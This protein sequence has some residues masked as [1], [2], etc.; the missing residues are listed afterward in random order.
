VSQDRPD[1]WLTG[2]ISWPH[3]P[4]FRPTVGIFQAQN[5]ILTAPTF[6]EPIE[7]FDGT[8]EWVCAFK[9]R[10]PIQAGEPRKPRLTITCLETGQ[11]LSGQAGFETDFATDGGQQLSIE[12]LL[13]IGRQ[14]RPPWSA[15]GFQS[16]LELSIVDQIQLIYI[17]FLGREPDQS[18]LVYYTRGITSGAKTILDVRDEILSSEEFRERGLSP[19]ERVGS[20]IVWGGLTQSTPFLAPSSW[21][22]SVVSPEFKRWVAAYSAFVSY[23]ESISSQTDLAEHLCKLALG[24]H[25]NFLLRKKWQSAHSIDIDDWYRK[26]KQ[27][28]S[29]RSALPPQ[30]SYSVSFSEFLASMQPTPAKREDRSKIRL[31]AVELG[32]QVYGRCAKLRH[33]LYQLIASFDR[34]N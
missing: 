6:R 2:A 11:I 19:E 1:T 5:L 16:F 26:V 17:D 34:R 29:E 12:D 15:S 28:Q 9:V 23:V 22:E 33:G 3:D 7:R 24:H 32:L 8:T 4:F 13:A 21:P 18:G 27:R 20:W 25:A 31:G 14:K 10:S 30:P